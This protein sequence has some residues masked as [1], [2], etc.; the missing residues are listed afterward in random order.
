[1][2]VLTFDAANPGNFV[3][4]NGGGNQTIDNTTY[5]HITLSNAGTKSLNGDINVHGNW[6]RSGTA[7]FNGSGNE[8]EFNAPATGAAQTI[9]SVGTETFSNLRINS[10]FATSPQLTF[11]N[12]NV[13]VSGELTFSQGHI[14]LNTKVLTLG[15]ANGLTHNGN[16]SSGWAYNGTITRAFGTGT[17]T[18]GN[19][20]GLLP[21][22]T[23]TNFRPFY[24]G[25]SNPAS[26]SGTISLTHSDAGTTTA[27][28]I[29][30]TNPAAT[31]I[32][33]REA[34]WKV[35]TTGG[36]TAAFDISYGGDGLGVVTNVTHLR[37]MLLNSV[38]ASN[39]AGSGT[40]TSP[41]VQ[42]TGLTAAQMTNDFYIGS[43][44]AASSLPVTIVSFEGVA[45]N[46]GVELSWK[47][48][49]EINNDYFTVLHSKTGL[50]SDFSPIG[51]VTGSGTT[52]EEHKYS[53]IHN[54][55]VTGKNYYM[56]RQTD[57]DGKNSAAEA[58]VVDVSEVG[59]FISIYP[60]PLRQDRTLNV[61][62]GSLEPGA[63]T[64]FHVLDM[65]GMTIRKT[66]GVSDETGIIKVSF[67]FADMPVGLYVLKVR[68]TQFKFAVD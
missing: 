33:R 15:G 46:F 1:L 30:D 24:F 6:L 49:S 50:G 5:W 57:F 27:V 61:V 14:N 40:T 64:E 21:M 17:V 22:G 32:I 20:D 43:S 44:N 65:R 13:T 28:S 19:D 41:R 66:I 51:T 34:P 9:T 58:I 60:N 56:L 68:D 38:I 52:N 67:D 29:A 62:L 12:N 45:R 47:T 63:S 55:P 59:S 7:T 42:R 26:S 35:T 48:E 54:R 31:I 8:V 11:A 36:G 53:F 16:A 10:S 25:K 4:Y 2:S 23:S 3:N 37:S 18:I 39:V